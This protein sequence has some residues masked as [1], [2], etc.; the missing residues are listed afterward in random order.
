MLS[1]L[2]ASGKDHSIRACSG[3]HVADFYLFLYDEVDGGSKAA[4]RACE[5][6]VSKVSTL[7]PARLA[8]RKS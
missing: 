8:R 4:G 5:T 7:P 6:D 2:P 3:R 1:C